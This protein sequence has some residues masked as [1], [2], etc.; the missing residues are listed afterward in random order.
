M[1][2]A[3]WRMNGSLH[4]FETYCSQRIKSRQNPHRLRKKN[5]ENNNEKDSV[6]IYRPAVHS[7]AGN[8][9]DIVQQGR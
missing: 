2:A 7:H 9:A 1:L 6:S 3:S 8:I 4:S 5:N